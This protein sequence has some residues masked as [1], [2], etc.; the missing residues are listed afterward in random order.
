MATYLRQVL[1]ES[2]AQAIGD[3]D[4]CAFNF[5]DCHVDCFDRTHVKLV[6]GFVNFI[7]DSKRGLANMG[8]RQF[9]I[10]VISNFQRGVIVGFAMHDDK[11]II[12]IGKD[13]VETK[14]EAVDEIFQ[15]I[16]G[17]AINPWEVKD[18]GHIGIVHAHFILR[19]EH[20]LK[21]NFK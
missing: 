13:G 20:T 17:K 18:S 1:F 12:P 7:S 8:N 2:V 15:G 19:D 10:D 5:I 4:F 16:V 3:I 21:S 11:K 9:H 14:S 6:L